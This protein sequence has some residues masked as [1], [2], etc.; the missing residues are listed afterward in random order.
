[1][2]FKFNFLFFFI[3]I[4]S[5]SQ[6]SITIKGSVTDYNGN[7]LPYVTVLVEET[8]TKYVTSQEGSFMIK[9]PKKSSLLFKSLGYQTKRIVVENEAFLQVV[10]EEKTEDLEEV[11]VIGYGI[12]REKKS[13]GTSTFTVNHDEL[14]HSGQ[15]SLA[16]ALS[17]KVAGAVISTS[18]S[19]SGSSSGIIL[20]GVNSLNSSNQPLIIVDGV[21]INNYSVFSSNFQNSFDFG[22]GIDGINVE[23][24]E[25]LTIVKGA[26]EAA[27]YGSRAANGVINITTKQ[28][29]TQG[30]LHVDISSTVH[31]S[32][33]LKA[34]KYQN[35]FG[36]GFGGAPGL[37]E[38]VSFGPRLTGQ[39]LPWGNFVN[40]VQR[41][42]AFRAQRN[43]IEEFFT[44]GIQTNKRVAV[45]GGTKVL[46][47]KVSF[48]NNQNDGIYPGSYDTNDRNL[49]HGS[50]QANLNRIKFGANLNYV[51]IKGKSVPGG[52]SFTP[53]NGLLQIPVDIDV[54]DLSD[55]NNP[56]NS[57]DNYFTPFGV[58]NPFYALRTRGNTLEEKRF[59]SSW[60]ANYKL[61]DAI[62]FN[63]TFGIDKNKQQVTTFASQIAP[64]PGSPNF[65]N[66][67]SEGFY[68]EADI[69][70]RQL[71]HD[72]TIDLSNKFSENIRASSTIGLNVNEVRSTVS[73]ISVATQEDPGFFSLSNSSNSPDIGVNSI[74][75]NAFLGNSDLINGLSKRRLIGVFATTTLNYKEKLFLTGNVRNDWTSTLPAKNRSILYGGLNSAW[76]FT[77]SFPVIK[78]VI[79]YGKFRLGYGETGLGTDPFNV[80][81]EIRPTTI[82]NQGFNGVNFPLNGVEAFEQGTR[83]ENLNLKAERRQELE[84]GTEL[85]LLN[86]RLGIDLT[87]YYAL[88]KDQILPLPLAPTTGNSF[89]IAN[90]GIISNQGIELLF[91]V[92]WLKNYHHFSWNTSF[93]YSK[94]NSVLEELN[95]NLGQVVLAGT[96]EIILT[97]R[98]GEKIGLIEGRVSRRAPDGR[99]IVDNRGIPIPSNEREVYGDTQY[100]YTLGLSNTF[101]YKNASLSFML[102]ARQGGLLFSRTARITRFTGNSITT[103]P[104]NREPFVVPNSVQE[105]VAND[106]T[107]SFTENETPVVGFFNYLNSNSQ[108]RNE[109]IDKSFVKLREVVLNY[110]FKDVKISKNT[111][112]KQVSLSIIGRNLKIW[113]PKENQ[114]I[115]PEVS[116]FGTDLRSHFGEF[117][118]APNTKSISFSVKA[119]F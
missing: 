14:N 73:S 105:I 54:N 86:N 83:A 48:S 114:F 115:D 32:S 25:S 55:L 4:L 79:N 41:E 1:M 67:R 50:F 75:G 87:Y 6:N 26:S 70:V 101:R 23:D 53:I 103:T 33:V 64:S 113:T 117:S 51:N 109:V 34:P 36:Q 99:I 8:R 100:D 35:T 31:I 60:F 46:S 16:N 66:V 19:A 69:D 2:L 80:F 18:S 49:I 95:N 42:K 111:K 30:K 77:S 43:Q 89:Q 110:V 10:L 29:N 82:S 45:Y 97:A 72:F 9:T 44:N 119:S 65:G 88:T 24:I 17:G 28:K 56:F 39:I 76:I 62:K 98:E 104:N 93:N 118:L 106:G 78:N 107:V 92:K 40:G 57:V 21:P 20:R 52:E 61:S 5:F 58:I 59:Y 37:S 27:V 15:I 94:T 102:D 96:D 116:S 7:V 74:L 13:L 38:N 12:K 85:S 90:V 84:V 108:D 22:R 3:T 63:Y 71:N 112:I 47:G 11:V 68:G 91:H 81:S